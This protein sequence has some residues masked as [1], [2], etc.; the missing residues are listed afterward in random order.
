[1]K[2]AIVPVTPFRQNCSVIWCEET[3]R[4]AVVDPG[5]DLDQVMAVVLEHEVKLEKI[6]LTHGHMDHAA[7]TA[8]LAGEFNLPIEGPHEADKFWIDGI[9]QAAARY[10][11]P[12]ARVFTPDRWLHHGDTVSVG[13]M[14]LDVL[15]CPGHTPGHVVFL[16]APSR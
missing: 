16:H 11:F 8:A 7:G 14:T 10:G 9:P 15:H 12:P 6:L 13:A 3:M 1:M 2:C 4:G 5:G